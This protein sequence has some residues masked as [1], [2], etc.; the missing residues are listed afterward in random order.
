MGK[1]RPEPA[2]A[3]LAFDAYIVQPAPRHL[4]KLAAQL[5]KPYRT[6]AQWAEW[7][8]WR[9]RALA[10]DNRLIEQ[11]MI[12]RDEEQATRSVMHNFY[13]SLKYTLGQYVATVKRR[14]ETG[15]PVDERQAHT[16]LRCLELLHKD[17]AE[18][19]SEPID[20]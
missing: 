19:L 1:H 15:A 3:R 2:H 8:D 11:A 20:A 16:A 10:H 7:Y 6:I 9:A 13:Q 5:G 14:Q 4:P 17:Y 12:E 18:I